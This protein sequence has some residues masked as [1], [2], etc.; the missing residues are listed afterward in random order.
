MDIMR[1]AAE[2]VRYR[3]FL[4]N[5]VIRDIKVRY[6]R[7]ALGVLWVMLNPLFMMLILYMVFSALFKVSTVNYTAYIISGLIIWNFFSQ[8]TTTAVASL[9]G[10][11]NLIK[12]IY[13]PKAIF[14]LSTVLSAMI[15][16]VFSL[17]PLVIIFYLTGTPI[18]PRIYLVPII[19]ILV[20]MFSFGITLFLSTL[21]VFFH[22]TIYIYEVILMAWMW[23]TPLFYP[24]SIVPEKFRMILEL[25]P[26]YY[27]INVFRGALYMENPL[28]VQQFLYCFLLSLAMLTMGWL[29][30]NRLR[31]KVVF[32]L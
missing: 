1:E 16:F 26:F 31:E 32:Y 30:F 19:I 7:S 24:V 12:K 27:F 28:F 8:S 11:S 10:N 5:L 6:K 3:E 4:K 9:T 2:I 25:N 21:T 20:A 18:G 22:D 17:V 13:I 23:V 14:P 29:F 15:N